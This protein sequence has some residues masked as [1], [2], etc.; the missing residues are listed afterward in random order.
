MGVGLAL[1]VAMFATL[2]AQASH[3]PTG[4]PAVDCAI[5]TAT[6]WVDD[7]VACYQSNNPGLHATAEASASCTAVKNYQGDIMYWDADESYDA[8]AW[9]DATVPPVGATFL[10]EGDGAHMPAQS[11]SA[12]WPDDEAEVSDSW[13]DSRYDA[14]RNGHEVSASAHARADAPAYVPADSADSDSDACPDDT[15]VVEDLVSEVESVP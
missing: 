15:S 4:S 6:G 9:E 7:P 12:K 1:V 10:A 11:E 3:V 2:P 14:R 5:D 13:T 8:H